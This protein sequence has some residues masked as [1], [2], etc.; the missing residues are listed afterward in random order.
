MNQLRPE[1]PFTLVVEQ[2]AVALEGALKLKEVSYIE[3][4][5][6]AAAELKHGTITLIEKGTPV[7][8]LINDPATADLTRGNI[9]EV[10]SRGASVIT[11]VAK[12]FANENDDIVL[13]EVDYYMSPLLIVVPAQLIAYYASKNK[14]LDVD[15]PRNLAKSVTVE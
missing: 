11:F 8:A 6:F 14:G 4:E 9:R 7:I 10:E 12:Q 13:P 1:M 15:K 3:T 2:I 5:G